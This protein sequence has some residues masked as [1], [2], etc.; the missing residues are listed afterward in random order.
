[1]GER[2]NSRADHRAHAE[3]G[4]TPR[5]KR[6][7]QPL[8][9]ILGSG[10]ERVDTLGAE[11]LAHGCERG[12][13]TP[14]VY[15]LRWPCAIFLTFFFSDPRATREARLALGAAFLRAARFS[16]LRSALSVMFVVF[17]NWSILQ[18]FQSAS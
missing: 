6:L 2:E 10:N 12:G 5:T 14:R 15:L 13:C 17:M 16:F 4:E 18:T 11:E 9:R 1:S 8:V 3:R 7:A